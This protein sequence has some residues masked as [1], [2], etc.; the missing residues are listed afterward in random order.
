[1]K[2]LLSDPP[3]GPLLPGVAVTVL[4]CLPREVLGAWKQ[5]H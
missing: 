2:S 1:M 5:T 4:V 3:T